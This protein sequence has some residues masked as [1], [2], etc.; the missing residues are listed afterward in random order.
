MGARND[1]FLVGPRDGSPQTPALAKERAL[2]FGRGI[3]RR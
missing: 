2:Q 1:K 3:S